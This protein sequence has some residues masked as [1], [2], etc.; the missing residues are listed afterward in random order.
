MNIDIKAEPG[1]IILI[2]GVPRSGKSS[3]VR[4]IQNRF[5]GVWMNIGVDRY[6]NMLPDKAKPGI[7]LR[8]GGE[9]PDLEPEVR[10]MYLSLYESIAAH[11]RHGLHVAADT[12]HHEFYSSELHIYEDCMKL[13]E[14]LP[15]YKI[16]LTCGIDEI[17]RRREATGYPALD[18]NGN[19]LNPVLLWQESIHKN[20]SYDLVLDTSVLTPAQCADKIEL[21]INQQSG[22]MD[23]NAP[24]N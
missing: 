12:G 14:G 24:K 1:K 15:V 5:E 4:E 23:Q 20:K 21:L 7:G 16:G 2:N 3:I 19:I 17:I 18:S 8:P 6:M 22:G 11:S 9:R 10:R 13:L